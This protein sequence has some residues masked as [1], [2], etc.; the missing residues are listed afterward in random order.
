MKTLTKEILRW[1][2]IAACGG[3]GVW[4]LVV[5]VRRC[6]GVRW[7][8][9]WYDGLAFFVLILPLLRAAPFLAM[10]YLCLCRQYRKLFLVLG[11][12]GAII[13]FWEFM[14]LPE[15]L[16]LYQ[17]MDHRIHEDHALTFLGL[18]LALLFLFGPAYA[19]AWFFR[20]CH[21]LAYPGTDRRPKTR[22]TG[23]LV[24]SGAALLLTPVIM[25]A[26][27]AAILVANIH[28]AKTVAPGASLNW[29]FWAAGLYV[30]GSLLLFLGLV[31][32]RPIAEEEERSCA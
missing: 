3:Y 29:L 30:I 11:V 21:R 24:W 12:V 32:R 27:S 5:A 4:Q 14:S 23:W 2:V 26:A 20:L 8:G 1:G 19:A 17:L 25:V 7:N 10:A 22:A 9:D 13:V 16:G 15:Q 18:P 6:V 31:R 28:A